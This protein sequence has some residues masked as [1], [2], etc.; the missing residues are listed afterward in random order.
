M[1]FKRWQDATPHYGRR[2]LI[3]GPPNTLKTT[4]CFTWP[5]HRQHVSYSGE[6][7]YET[8]PRDNPDHTAWI[9]EVADPA[10]LSPH[11]VV[12]EV[13][14]LTTELL[15]GKHGECMTFVGDGVH[16]LY[17]WYFERAWLDLGQREETVGQAYGK[18]HRDF[19][20]YLNKVLQSQVPYVVMTAWE[21]R[22]KDDPT[23]KSKNAP[24]HIF[25]DLPGMMASRIV[26][27]FS[28][29]LYAEVDPP[30]PQGKVTARWQIRPAGKVWGVGVKLPPEM[31]A[32]LPNKLEPPDF[33]KLEPLLK[34]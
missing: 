25:P 24:S 18:A 27:E 19:G 32:R 22:T 6:K 3:S 31:A 11:A 2:V 10:K 13:E 5:A 7:G 1:P 21:G 17:T 9:W 23:D 16:K 15:A 14:T 4:A 28:V 26:G 34:P 29:V 20:A 12:T 30:T 33:R 8:I